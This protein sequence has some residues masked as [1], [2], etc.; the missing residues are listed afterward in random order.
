MHL[1]THF[2]HSQFKNIYL[3][4]IK[5]IDLYYWP[6]ANG[7]KIP[8]LLEELG[9]PYKSFTLNIRKGEHKTEEFKVINPLLRIPA[10]VDHN[11]SSSESSVKLFE[12]AAILIYLAEKYKKFIPADGSASK[13]VYPWLFWQVGHISATF[14]QYQRF[15]DIQSSE[16][17]EKIKHDLHAEVSRLYRDFD[18]H[19]SLH[20]YVA[21][22]Y[23]IA[24]IALF[25]FFQP[26]RH[27]QNPDDYPNIKR[28]A[29]KIRERPAIKKSY[30]TALIIAPEEKS[31]MNWF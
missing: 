29:A 22:E 12:S 20:K 14:G 9:V 23:S 31:L 3:R 5:L 8:I 13:I 16:V 2:A 21:D 10:I 18:N 24:D 17:S 15:Q 19:L 28:W 4:G 25:P 11:D 1:L 30:S 27:N 7:I 26:K 6:T